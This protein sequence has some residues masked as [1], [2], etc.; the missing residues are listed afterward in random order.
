MKKRYFVIGVLAAAITAV[1]VWSFPLWHT[2]FLLH[3]LAKSKSLDCRIQVILDREALSENQNQFLQAV[4]WILGIE[5]NSCLNWQAE[6]G[7][8][9]GQG[10]AK[11]YCNALKEPVTEVYFSEGSTIVNIEMLYEALQNNFGREHPILGNM[12]PDW[13]YGSYISLEQI[14]DMFQVD[15]EELLTQNAS[16]NMIGQS[17]WK[18]LLLLNQMEREK[19]KNGGWQFQT[20]WNGWQTVLKTEKKGQIQRLELSG[21]SRE[22]TQKIASF[23]ASLCS[24]EQESIVFPDSVMKEEEIK[25]FQ[26]LWSIVRSFTEGRK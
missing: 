12:L 1:G 25:Q 13:K 16:S 17:L 22:H 15:F 3:S 14:Q 23:F 10:T 24:G 20:S 2:A 26:K 9:Q 5:E 21:V 7:F 11:I 19:A 18:N 8:S 4:S 6:G